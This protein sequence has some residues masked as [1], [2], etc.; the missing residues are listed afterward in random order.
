MRET[1]DFYFADY[2]MLH[3]YLAHRLPLPFISFENKK[4]LVFQ[5]SEMNKRVKHKDSSSIK[6]KSYYIMMIFYLKK[7]I[8]F[9]KY[10]P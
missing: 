5:H 4:H 10:L 8:K 1:G 6:K 7:G 3:F 9:T 2:L